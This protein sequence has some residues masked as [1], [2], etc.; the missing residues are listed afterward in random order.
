[1][2]VDDYLLRILVSDPVACCAVL[3]RN[4][5]R[6]KAFAFHEDLVA[7]AGGGTQG[8]IQNF[9]RFSYELV[10]EEKLTVAVGPSA[11]S[12]IF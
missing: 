3:E 9:S 6:L 4:G 2:V 1:M 7:P 8:S 12:P 11:D 5:L 10:G